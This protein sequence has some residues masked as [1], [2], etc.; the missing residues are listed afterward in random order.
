MKK[1]YIFNIDKSMNL[2]IY[3]QETIATIK[4]V[5]MMLR[6]LRL[7]LC[8]VWFYINVHP[9]KFLPSQ[10]FEGNTESRELQ[11]YRDR[12]QLSMNASGNKNYLRVLKPSRIKIIPAGQAQLAV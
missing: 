4:A 2:G 11:G 9:L 1:E 10:E 6:T 3:T 12:E 7:C 8:L 5:I